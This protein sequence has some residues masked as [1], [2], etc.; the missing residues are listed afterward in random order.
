VL[1]PVL[2]RTAASRCPLY[3]WAAAPL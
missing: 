2:R 1:L 3:T